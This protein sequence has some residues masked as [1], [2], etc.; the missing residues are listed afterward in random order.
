MTIEGIVRKHMEA[1]HDELRL[2]MATQKPLDAD[3]ER[4]YP[5]GHDFALAVITEIDKG[6]MY[7]SEYADWYKEEV[8]E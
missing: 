3:Y 5:T 8:G 2:Y 1:M 4:D 7:A 6:T